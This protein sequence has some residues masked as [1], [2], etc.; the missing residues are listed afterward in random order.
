MRR[1]DLHVRMGKPFMVQ[2]P[3]G[4]MTPEQRQQMTDEMMYRLADLLP[5]DL[6]G[7]YSEQ[8]DQSEEFLK[9]LA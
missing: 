8:T 1:T 4:K 9:D 5:E 6:R 3:E 7:K 2:K